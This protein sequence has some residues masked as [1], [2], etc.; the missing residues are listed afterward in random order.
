LSREIGPPTCAVVS[1]NFSV[2]GL[3][4]SKPASEKLSTMLSSV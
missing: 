4:S 1:M 3:S 2:R